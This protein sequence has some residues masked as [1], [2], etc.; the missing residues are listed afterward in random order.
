VPMYEKGMDQSLGS[1]PFHI[2]FN[3]E[4]GEIYRSTFHIEKV[5]EGFEQYVPY[6][7]W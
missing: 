5:L 3:F 6:F 1:G 4:H 7:K 2:V